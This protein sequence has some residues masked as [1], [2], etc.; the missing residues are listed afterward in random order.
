MR[1]VVILGAGTAGTIMANRLMRLLAREVRAHELTITIVDRDDRHLYQP[2]LLFIPFGIY[3][4]GDVVQPRRRS[5]PSQASFVLGDVARVD[6]GRSV[7]ELGDGRTLPYDVLVVK[8]CWPA[9][10]VPAIM[11]VRSIAQTRAPAKLLPLNRL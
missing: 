10:A 3:D 2:G 7:V 9:A 1:H 6:A 11:A 5:L 8:H 4:E